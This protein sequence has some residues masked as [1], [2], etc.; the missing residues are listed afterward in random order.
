MIRF[1]GRSGRAQALAAALDRAGVG[2]DAGD[3]GLCLVLGGDGT[4]LN[5]IH[6]ADD[7]AARTYLGINCGNLGF[8]MN[9]IAGDEA[10][11]ARAVGEIVRQRRYVAHRFPR[12]RARVDLAGAAAGGSP[13]EALAVN[14]IY[15]ERQGGDTCHL[16]VEVDGVEVVGSMSCDGIIA[17]TP[18]GS[19]AYSYSAGGSPS[20]PL[21]QAFH[22]TP[23]CPHTPRLAPILL[24]TTSR[25]RIDVL[26]PGRRP[27]RVVTDGVAH[28][29][30]TGVSVDWASGHEVSIAFVEGHHFT[31]T[32]LRKVLRT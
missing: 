30:A 19:T 26:L 9:D 17:A 14:D 16:R 28:G 23:I 5:A 27:A 31:G 7:G 32:L 13:L 10:A 2:E 12:L 1:V 8:L 24:P 20:H 29:D 18:L 4:M 25:V 6:G 21:V 22:L 15:V 11:V 3:A